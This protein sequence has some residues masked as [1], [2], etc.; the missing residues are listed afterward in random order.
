MEIFN[1]GPMELILIVLIMF[2]FLGPTEM[3]RLTRRFG[4][5]LRKAS[6]SSLWLDVKRFSDEVQ[7]LPTRL[8]REAGFDEHMEEI[9]LSA[10]RRNTVYGFEINLPDETIVVQPQEE[11]PRLAAL[12]RY[13]P[14][15]HFARPPFEKSAQKSSQP[16][17]IQHQDSTPP[18]SATSE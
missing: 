10:R 4:V 8:A 15:R 9:R 12:R 3:I 1:V 11:D 18:E 14:P 13:R 7:S 2:I 16:S 6:Q 5:M 17:S